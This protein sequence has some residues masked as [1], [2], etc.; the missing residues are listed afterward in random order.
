MQSLIDEGRITEEEAR[1]HPHR[2][3]ILRAVDGVHE[4]EPD[5]FTL[6]VAAGDRFL[7][8]CDGCSGV[9]VRRRARRASSARARSTTPPSR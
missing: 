5:L 1:V 6:E 2:N 4:P 3:L 7:L 8:C 9:L